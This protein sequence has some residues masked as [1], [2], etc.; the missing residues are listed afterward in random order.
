MSAV[1]PLSLRP[2]RPVIEIDGARQDALGGGLMQL[3]ILES[4]EGLARC[5]LMF[6]NW[7][8]S[9]NAGFRYFDRTLL[10]FGK[11]LRVLV[12]DDLLFEGRIGA[13]H[14][15][16]LEGGTPQIAV[17]AEDR[18]QDLRMTRRT[19]SF[20]DV[21]VAEV[22]RRIA[23]DHGLQTEISLSGPTHKLLA[24]LNQSDLAF[25]RDLVRREGGQLWI[26]AGKL[27]AAPRSQ[28]G[29]TPV[30]L[31]WAGTLREFEVCA[32]LAH[33]RTALTASGW[34]VADK[35]VAKHEA[36]ESAIAS[37]LR[38]GLSGASILQ[39]A[40][41]ARADTVAHVAPVDDTEARAI[42][43]AQFR[44][45]ARRFV[46]GRGVAQAPSPLRVGGRIAVTGVGPLF[47]GEYTLTEV[48][49]RFDQADGLRTEFRCDRPALG[50]A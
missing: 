22:L 46:V 18:L 23:S 36:G 41:G 48:C 26:D 2:S 16:F 40:F 3:E 24:Q 27:K 49:V 11:P 28:R 15:R 8:G 7:G 4:E 34:G 47:E 13:L 12:G 17:L 14:A 31:A 43:E 25:A 33:Q 9:G 20:N 19:R 39:Q 37:E 29:G 21:A 10:E 1:A 44:H 5:Q 38:G 50:R 6:G 32:D 35:R 45:M 30:A 42:A